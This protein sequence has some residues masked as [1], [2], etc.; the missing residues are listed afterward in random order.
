M[1]I[2]YGINITN[3]YNYYKIYKKNRSDKGVQKVKIVL[4]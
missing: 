1:K 2:D 4:Y 3:I